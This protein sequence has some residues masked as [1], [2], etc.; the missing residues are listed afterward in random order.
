MDSAGNWCLIESDPGVFTQLIRKFGAKGVQVEELWSID[1]SMFENLRPVHGLI[2]LFKYLRHEEP[3][4][5]VVTDN[6]L[7]K[8]YFAKQVINNACATQAVISLLL[9]CTHPDVDLGPELTKLKE[10]SMSFD[11]KMR[12]LTLSNSQTIRSAHNSMSQQVIFEMDPK[13]ATKEEDAY[14]F[15]GYM[16]IDGRLYELDGLREGPIDHGPIAP[17]QDWLDVVRPIIMKRISVYTEGEMHFN[18]MALVSDRKMIYERQLEELL[19]ETQMLGG[20]ETDELENEIPRLRMLIEQEDVKMARY[21]QEMARRRH[22]YLPFIIVL[23]KILAEEK[24][25]VPL[26]EKAKER[27]SK[28]GTKKMKV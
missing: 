27:A 6:R 5:T 25:L 21:Q 13:M 16:P 23:L 12:G 26:Y 11:P 20:M 1:D 3:S 24:K 2:F 9:N 17:D 18:L 15:I 10:F 19:N 4:G 22:N 8:I 14:H 28:K 7:E